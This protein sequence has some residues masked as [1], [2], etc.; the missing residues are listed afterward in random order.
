LL[1]LGIARPAPGGCRYT[2]EQSRLLAGG[3]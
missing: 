1:N 2:A 3:R